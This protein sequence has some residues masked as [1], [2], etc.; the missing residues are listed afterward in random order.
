MNID[1]TDANKAIKRHRYVI[2]T[3]EELR[4]DFNGAKYFSVL[5]QN[6]G[7]NQYQ[8]APGDS[9][10]I[11]AFRT[12]RGIKRFKR[13]HFGINAAAEIFQQ[14]NEKTFAD[15]ENV[16]VI[17]DDFIVYGKTKHEHNVA[18]ARLLKRAED[19]GLTFG[20][21][22]VQL[23]QKKVKYFGVAFTENGVHPD[24][25]KV[26]DLKAARPPK[27]AKEALSYVC[28]A[29]ALCQDFVP[30]FA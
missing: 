26:A 12:H 3:L 16:R 11:T 4:H 15:I 8:L 30:N 13:L 24:E 1:M 28:M 10:N 18:L 27:N 5:D 23:N 7:Y 6:C 29:Q 25:E 19:C 2:P 17:Y 21:K 20:R 14:E 9:R 22:K